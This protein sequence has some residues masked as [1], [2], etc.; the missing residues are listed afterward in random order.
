[1]KYS[2]AAKLLNERNNGKN[3]YVTAKDIE[4]FDFYPSKYVIEEEVVVQPMK[5]SRSQSL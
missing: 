2:A 5:R 4:F 3:I 1:M